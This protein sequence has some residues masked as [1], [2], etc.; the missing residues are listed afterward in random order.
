MW[1][2]ARNPWNSCQRAL[3]SAGVGAC[4]RMD[5]IGAEIGAQGISARRRRQP[6]VVVVVVAV[7]VA[8][9]VATRAAI[10]I[11]ADVQQ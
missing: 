3:P 8:V 6:V 2:G 11:I 10:N 4:R 1:P 7:V 5:C 9:A